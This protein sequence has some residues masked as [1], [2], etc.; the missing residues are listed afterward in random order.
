MKK[1]YPLVLLLLTLTFPALAQVIIYH[2]NFSGT[3]TGYTFTAGTWLNAETSPSTGYASGG[4]YLKTASNIGST[5]VLHLNNRFSTLGYTGITIKW[6]DYRSK[7]NGASTTSNSPVKLFYSIDN[8]VS[9]L[10]ASVT[11]NATTNN[12]WNQAS[13]SL[14]IGLLTAEKIRLRWEIST[15]ANQQDYYAID[16]IIIEGTPE[17]GLS[18]FAWKSRPDGENPFVASAATPAHYTVDGVSMKWSSTS[19]AGVSLAESFVGTRFQSLNKSLALVQSG[20][21]ATKGTAVQVQFNKPVEDLTFTLLDIDQSNSKGQDKLLIKGYSSGKE[22]LLVKEKLFRTASSQYNATAGELLGVSGTDV[23]ATSNIANV[24]VSFGIAV[25]RVVISYYNADATPNQQEVGIYDLSWRKDNALSPLPVTL[26]SFKG[27]V[28]NTATVLNWST[29]TEINNEKFVI[30]RS[31]DGRTFEAIGTVKGNGNSSV[32]LK[33]SFTDLNPLN[34]TNY[35]RLRQ[36]DYDGTVNLSHVIALNFA[37]KLQA[38]ELASVYP[39][40]ATS[41]VTIKVQAAS[42]AATVQV[43]DAASKSIAQYLSTTQQEIMLPVQNLK[44]GVYFVTVVDG[45]KRET[46]RFIKH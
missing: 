46:K 5:K 35:Y 14:P 28:Q 26:A 41:A 22:V 13:A 10:E 24:K 12:V 27:N 38:K 19:D 34:G 25:D 6:T 21:T 17:S 1:L 29:A 9:F 11:Q 23:A 4:A 44:S 40:L 16:D 30:E 43:T 39:T 37:G 36:V 45:E 8:G 32:L 33:Y 2:E 3:V 18:S 7:V 15:P 42:G 20:A 31:Q